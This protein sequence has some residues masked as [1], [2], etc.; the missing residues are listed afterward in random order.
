M[1]KKKKMNRA[2]WQRV[3]GVREGHSE[4]VTVEPVMQRSGRRAARWRGQ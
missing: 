1:L 4:E 2:M 3:I